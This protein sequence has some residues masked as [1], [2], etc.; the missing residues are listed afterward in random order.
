MLKVNG[1]GVEC[2]A[3]SVAPGGDRQT[4]GIRILTKCKECQ[5]TQE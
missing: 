5:I 1:H 3:V 2:I 4:A